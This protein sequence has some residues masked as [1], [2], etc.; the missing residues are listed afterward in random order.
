MYPASFKSLHESLLTTRLHNWTSPPLLVTCTH[1]CN[2]AYCKVWRLCTS[3]IVHATTWCPVIC[4]SHHPPAGLS[5]KRRMYW[6]WG[7]VRR[8]PTPGYPPQTSGTSLWREALAEDSSM[9]KWRRT[10]SSTRYLQMT[11]A[12][13]AVKTEKINR[14]KVCRSAT[15]TA[16][17]PACAPVSHSYPRSGWKIRQEIAVERH[18]RPMT[19]SLM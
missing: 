11:T 12:W 15:H 18:W 10:S 17:P 9:R 1:V 5:C 2:S 14:S 3:C 13:T 8:R 6:R 4:T 16:E 7:S 19:A